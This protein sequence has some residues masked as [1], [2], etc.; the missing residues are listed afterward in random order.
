MRQTV[1]SFIAI[2][3]CLVLQGCISISTV[4]MGRNRGH[5]ALEMIEEPERFYTRDQVLMIP[6]SGM[7]RSGGRATLVSEPGMLIALKD[8]LL[9][10][11]KNH[12]IK[13]VIL[14]I[15][16]PGGSVTA[17]DLI[18]RE[19]LAFKERTGMPIIAHLTDTA[20]SG[21]IYLAM[22]AD[23]VYALPTT[24]TGSIGVLVMMPQMHELGR[25]IGFDMEVVKSGAKKDAGSPWRPL[26]EAERANFQRLI[27]GFHQ[28]FRQV[29]MASR[30]DK[31][32]S[33]EQLASIADGRVFGSEE[34]RKAGLIDGIMYSDEVMTR[35]KELAGLED[36][37]LVSYEYMNAYRGHIYAESPRVDPLLGGRQGVG[38]INLFKLDF[39]ELTRQSAGPEFLYLWLP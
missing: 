33:E 36:A 19:L 22:A 31:G 2:I 24:V 13:A 11:E 8:R 25:K 15:D 37:G 23:E 1:A 20:A 18:H 4:G 14:R 6:L 26:S 27:D 16:S 21:G 39:G 7:V 10:A 38:E 12:R 34:A 30:K 9:A 29:I 32:M 17:S 28:R 35:A 5:V 3:C